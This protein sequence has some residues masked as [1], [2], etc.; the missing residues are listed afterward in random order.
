MDRL[1]KCQRKRQKLQL[2]E[3]HL[4]EKLHPNL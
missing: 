4:E 2:K 3:E 1:P